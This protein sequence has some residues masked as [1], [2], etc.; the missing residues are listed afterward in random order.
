MDATLDRFFTLFDK[1]Q[2][3]DNW[4]IESVREYQRML[5]EKLE[6]A[7]RVAEAARSKGLDPEPKVEVLIAKDMAERVEKLIGL[8]GLARRIRELEEEGLERDRICFRI[9][10]EITEG[11]F[12]R[13]DFLDA[14]DKSIRTAVAIMTEGVVAAPIEGI[15]KV[16]TDKN[17]DGSSY[18]KVYYAGPIRSAGGTAQ[19]ISVLIADY[20]R[21]KL[22]IGRYIPTDEEILR[23]CEEIQL[24]KKVANLQYLPTD[25][26]I[27]LIVSNCPVC[28]DGEPT[29][30][31]EVSGYRNL[32]RVE[33]NRIR[34]GM[35]LI[36]AEG[37]ALKAPKLKKMVDSLKI[38]GWDW[39]ERLIKKDSE[40]EFDVKPRGKYL[41]DLVA[42]RPVL[43]HPSKKGGFRLRY[44]RARNS[45]LATVGINPATMALIDFIAIGTQ[46][47]IERPGKAGSVVPVTT[48]EGPTVRLKNGDVLRIN[49]FKEALELKN[50]VEKILDLGEIL[51]NYGDFLE[52]NHPLMPASYTREW[53]E[54]ETG[55]K[56]AHIDEDTALKLSDEL[57]V[58][59][60][61]DFTYL[62]HDISLEDF[63]YLRDY[64]SEKGKIDGQ[65][66]GCLFMPFDRRI[67]EILENLLVEHKVRD[68]I[69]IERWKVLVRCLGLDFKLRKIGEVRGESVLEAIKNVSGI[70]V[71]PKAPTRIGA[72]MGRP[73]KSKERR[74]SPPP[75]LLF[76]VSFAGGKRRDVKSAL[77]HRNGYN[78]AKGLIEVEIALRR[79]K[80][81]GKETFWLKCECGGETEQL[82][83]CPKCRIRD[84]SE[85]CKKCGGEMRGYAKRA[86]D[87]KALYERA[88]QNLGEGDEF[89]VVKGV[90]G[91]TSKNKIPERIEKGILRAKHDV[92]VFKDGT[93]RYDMTDLPLTHFKP[94]EIGVSV[95]KLRELG[96]RRDY[97]GRELRSEDQILELK[98][99][100]IVISR[101][102]AEYL[103]RVARFIDDLLVKFYKTEPFYRAEKIE[104]LI[105]HLV[106][107]LAPH[108][109]AGVLGR[110]VGFADILAC[111]AHP[112]FHAA[113]R[114]N[115]DGDEDCIMLLLDGLL[116]FSRHFLPE[117]RGGRMDAPL[118]LTVL[119]DPREVD[120][121]VHNMDVVSGYP[122][123]F[124]RATLEFSDPKVCEDLIEKVKDR[125]SLE[126]RFC[127][128]KFTHDTDIALGVKESAYKRLKTMEEKVERQME[129]ARR[130][131]A[132]EEHDVAE[133]IITIHF[134]PDI[135]GN[136]RAFSR[137]EFRCVECNEKYRR[138][139]LSG[140]CRRCGGNLTLTVHSSSI[141]KYLELSK[142]LCE[143]YNVSE[144]TR[145][146]L[147][148]IEYEIRSLIQE[149]KQVTLIDI[150]G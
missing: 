43:C 82:Y 106:I 142:K 7:Y 83:Y 127:T 95:E 114:R 16:S 3:D 72:R 100:D 6:E 113:K 144:Y 116:N 39:L 61:P 146:R 55:I 19:V 90:I 99:Q 8:K 104:D 98:P 48:I 102:C 28:I 63:C 117:K 109:S 131:S 40:E 22:G 119:V 120:K 21:R 136:L 57:G 76:P 121:E 52:N 5:S 112:Y 20:V 44:G 93:I 50:D 122:L 42:G 46:L 118:V 88:L 33:T 149:N 70:T 18:L 15:A 56:D 129:L 79:C 45:G 51:I 77:D 110:I 17:A 53:W 54:L 59:M 35:A 84:T 10:D 91:L 32:P 78:S 74:M 29:E 96:Y 81:C 24:Y 111:Y 80:V 138:L 14:I 60:H 150:L 12:G 75:H 133:R 71:R 87:I 140:R 128:L 26:E 143:E 68:G 2:E 97:M 134:L 30:E 103:L 132:V 147:R 38:D 41:S 25:D 64:I 85:F 123:E 9:A 73:E 47:K 67:K 148:L 141:V 125:L 1:E 11:K 4:A 130:I 115:C 135:I 34:G 126:T 62:W 65:K 49:S 27:R 89:E 94:R 108:T 139:P 13:M 86:V 137:Q 107:A 92:Y 105:G 124:Y 145:Q 36:I 37:I 31:E 101:D 58:P 66:K 69:V 23:Y